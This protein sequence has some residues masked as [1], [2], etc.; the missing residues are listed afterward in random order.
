MTHYPSSFSH[1]GI[2]VSDVASAVEYYREVVGWYLLMK[3][4]VVTD[5]A[6]KAMGTMCVP[7]R[8]DR[9]RA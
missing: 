2:S 3:P 8:S 5:D 7:A 9:A 6:Q 1:T 4:T